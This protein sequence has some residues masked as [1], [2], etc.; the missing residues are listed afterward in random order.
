MIGIQALWQ[1]CASFSNSNWIA[2]FIVQN[3]SQ[4]RFVCFANHSSPL[5]M[6]VY[7]RSLA[8]T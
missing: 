5:A 1:H 7:A 2:S 3:D 6:T 4:D 8:M